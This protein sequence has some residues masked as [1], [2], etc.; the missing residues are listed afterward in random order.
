MTKKADRWTITLINKAI[1]SNLESRDWEKLEGNLFI[2]LRYGASERLRKK[3]GI[4]LG[5]HH[6]DKGNYLQS[7][8]AYEHARILSRD[9]KKIVTAEL[10][11]LSDLLD[12]FEDIATHD[13]LLI[14]RGIVEL[15]WRPIRRKKI[16]SK[17]PK[18]RYPEIDLPSR[19]EM[20]LP[21]APEK[22]ESKI[23]YQI[24]QI[25]NA[26]D[27]SLTPEQ[28]FDKAA[29][30]LAPHVLRKIIEKRRQTGN[31]TNPS[32]KPIRTTDTP[33]KS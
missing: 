1:R 21:Q 12:E 17:G 32:S 16:P 24:L 2:G 3:A 25:F 9:T 31:D 10:A 30:I 23:T 14:L 11:V 20:L 26:F 8:L 13:D 33:K 28:R 6:T 15:I 7:I 4:A 18:K 19:I 5:N 22:P 29:K 27:P